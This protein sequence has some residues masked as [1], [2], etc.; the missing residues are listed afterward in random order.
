MLAVPGSGSFDGSEGLSFE[1]QA[2]P[3]A[4]PWQQQQQQ[5]QHAQHPVIQ[6]QN[7]RRRAG[8]DRLLQGSAGAEAA[9]AAGEWNFAVLAVMNVSV[10]AGWMSSPARV[11]RSH[12]QIV[13]CYRSPWQLEH[14]PESCAFVCMCCW[15]LVQQISKWTLSQL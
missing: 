14:H 2:A 9:A 8:L 3:H 6:Q 4:Q 1:A 7:M 15:F 13:D 12:T 5:Q 10:D 11:L